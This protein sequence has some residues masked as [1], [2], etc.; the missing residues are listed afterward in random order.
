MVKNILV[1]CISCAAAI[2]GFIF[3]QTYMEGKEPKESILATVASAVKGTSTVKIAEIEKPLVEHVL[4][5]KNLKAIY[6]TSWVAGTPSLRDGLIQL[7]DTTE[8]NAVVL[9]IKDYTGKVSFKTGNP[10]IDN[11]SCVEE[12]IKDIKSLIKTLHDKNIYVIG[13]VSVFQDPCFVE[14]HPEVAVKRMSD[15]GVWKDKKGLS[16]VDMSSE[17][18]WKYVV[19]IAKTSYELGFDE[20]NFD[21]VRFPSDGDMKNI[22]YLSGDTP[23]PQVFKKFFTYLDT[24]LR[25]G[26]GEFT[27]LVEVGTSTPAFEEKK[28]NSGMTM[29]IAKH[30]KGTA[31]DPVFDEYWSL[32]HSTSSSWVN[33]REE[34][35]ESKRGAGRLI[36]SADL[37]GMVT[38]Q[39]DDLGIGQI[40]EYALPFV[41]Y[42]YPMVY[43][44]HYPANW[45]GF[46]NPAAY[47]YE[48][49]HISMKQAAER[50][51]A[52][53][54]SRKKLMPW[55]QDFDLGAEY[56][57]D[58]VRTQ[59]KA[60]YDNNLDGWLIWNASNKYTKAAL[61]S[62]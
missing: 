53:G 23:K 9:D 51:E 11:G 47:P 12:R 48:V 62:E 55:I 18:A 21:Y 33:K 7:L 6:M 56:T 26:K 24:E 25:G 37:F 43:P 5:P 2:S 35:I 42:I 4:P 14:K 30:L 22:K 50:A 20:I 45:N 3:V 44:S 39:P 19:D 41:D 32:V 59:F 29:T 60:A 28:M 36:T 54:L 34:A 8:A 46:K 10:N 58:M 1:G 61:K 38:T 57:A 17:V 27:P 16:W 40:L 31:K 13:R 52:I 15:G 49:V